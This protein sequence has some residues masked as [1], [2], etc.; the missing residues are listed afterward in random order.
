MD[1]KRKRS[2]KIIIILAIVWFAAALPVPFMGANPDP[3]HPEQYKTY[4]EIAG[5]VSI[6]FIAMGVVWTLKPELATRGSS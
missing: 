4:L 3:Q 5:I 6:P 2:L 1:P